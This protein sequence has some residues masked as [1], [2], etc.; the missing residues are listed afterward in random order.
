M[1]QEEDGGL[2]PAEPEAD[3]TKFDLRAQIERLSAW[4]QAHPFATLI[5]CLVPAGLSILFPSFWVQCLSLI[6]GLGNLA[7]IGWVLLSAK[8][9]RSAP[10]LVVSFAAIIAVTQTFGGAY[11]ATLLAEDSRHFR[12]SP[13]STAAD[14]NNRRLAVQV[15]ADLHADAVA[16]LN[17]YVRRQIEQG[18]TAPD[19]YPFDRNLRTRPCPHIGLSNKILYVCEEP[20]DGRRDPETLYKVET[21]FN[22]VFKVEEVGDGSW[23]IIKTNDRRSSAVAAASASQTRSDFFDSMGVALVTFIYRIEDEQRTAPSRADRRL[24]VEYL[25]DFAKT[26]IRD[27]GGQDSLLPADNIFA[28][29]RKLRRVDTAIADAL[30][31]AQLTQTYYPRGPCPVPPEFRSAVPKARWQSPDADPNYVLRSLTPLD[32][33]L[34]AHLT[35]ILYWDIRS[36]EVAND[37]RDL[38]INGHIFSAMAV[39]TS[40][41]ADMSPNSYLAK[42]LLILQFLTYVLLIILILPMSFE[43]PKEDE[44]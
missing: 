20:P 4:I 32:L 41:F 26:T 42:A 28:E 11:A 12:F 18:D 22:S 31:C 1:D 8:E 44:A 33:V 16:D 23:R 19:G 10:R 37:R 14:F 40:G 13:Y 35:E 7:A 27:F 15:L 17:G 43:R 24:L 6:W 5:V 25:S 2:P 3:E 36:M 30:L 9:L 29:E 38:V 34:Q 39:M 21:W